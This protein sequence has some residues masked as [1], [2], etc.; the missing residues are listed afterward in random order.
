MRFFL[1]ASLG[2]G[3]LISFGVSAARIAAGL[4]GIN[5]DLLEQSSTNAAIDA[6]G[7]VLIGTLWK[8]DADAE[9][10]GLSR[11]ARGADLAGL[12]VRCVPALLGDAEESWSRTGEGE[13]KKAA[14]T[15]PLSSLRSGRGVE[16]RVVIVVA[17]KERLK[18]VLEEAQD[19]KE[20]LALND[21]VVVPVVHPQGTAPLGLDPELLE[22][23]YIALPAGG[24]WRSVMSDETAEAEQQG[25]NLESEG[26]CVIIKKNGRIGQRT[27]GVFLNRMVG[28]VAERREAGMDV[29]NI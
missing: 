7:L 5:V 24:A 21:L 23:D 28:E 2:A 9:E 1:Y 26:I 12:T 29:T 27:K 11:A 13:R 19:L 15:I 25:V 4:A 16:K 14:G 17:G 3:A 20:A 8:R 18:Q 22:Q 6:A 10:S